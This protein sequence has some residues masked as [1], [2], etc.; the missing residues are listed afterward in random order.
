MQMV[1]ARR[2]PRRAVFAY[3]LAIGLAL[4]VGIAAAGHSHDEHADDEHAHVEDAGGCVLCASGTGVAPSDPVAP[5]TPALCAN[6]V[7]SVTLPAP[8]GRPPVHWLARG[9]P[10]SN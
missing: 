3:L 7:S 2:R 5:A 8:V 6:G 9:P 1:R 10:L 4:Q